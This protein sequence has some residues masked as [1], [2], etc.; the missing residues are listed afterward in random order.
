MRG[1]VLAM[2]LLAGAAHAEEGCG[3]W[4]WCFFLAARYE[5]GHPP[6]PQDK[7]RAQA[8]HAAGVDL[9]L[10]ACDRGDVS[11]CGAGLS[12]ARE[13]PEGAVAYTVFRTVADR[14]CDQGYSG[15]CTTGLG[16]HDRRARK[17]R[18]EAARTFAD[19]SFGKPCMAGDDAA[20]L[21]W[22]QRRTSDASWDLWDPAALRRLLGVCLADRTA[23]C[24]TF[25]SVIGFLN[26][27]PEDEL[28]SLIAQACD[29]GHG[30][31]CMAMASL[32]GRRRD[33]SLAAA[34]NADDPD[35]CGVLGAVLF[36]RFRTGTGDLAPAAD[37]WARGCD[38]GH[39]PSCHYLKH[40][41][42]Q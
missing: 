31:A 32:D 24:E 22:L 11:A 7:V 5:E 17:P 16:S 21:N 39:V 28:L 2:L 19:T 40:L 42:R 18:T 9:A 12:A 4:R 1:L 6:L 38:L 27:A 10:E 30:A 8:L 35:G 26:L 13:R 14:L 37:A 29:G 3:T 33:D 20:C 41:S 34:C 15:A 23:D 36:G 25:Y